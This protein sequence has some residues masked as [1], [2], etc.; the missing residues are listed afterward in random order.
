MK[1]RKKLHLKMTVHDIILEMSEGNPGGMTVIM[2]MINVDMDRF[3]TCILQADKLNIRG[4]Q[5]WAGYKDWAGMD[6]QK[7]M[8][9]LEKHDMEMISVINRAC[10][11]LMASLNI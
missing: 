10:H 3:V 5:I 2:K 7:F 6:I 11:P 4:E 8:G 9:G 1:T